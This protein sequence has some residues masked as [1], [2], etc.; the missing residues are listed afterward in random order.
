MMNAL[1]PRHFAV[2]SPPSIGCEE[3][4]AVLRGTLFCICFALLTPAWAAAPVDLDQFRGRVV[5]LDFWASWCG[6]CKQSFPWMQ[7]MTNAYTGHGLSV[8]AVNLDTDRADAEKFLHEFRPTFEVR[9]D[10]KGAYAEFYHVKGMPSSV[11]IDRHGVSRFTHVGFL[12]VDGSVLEAQ[13][14]ELLA[15]K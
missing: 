1:T 14:Q 15:E 12:P 13:V 5:Y 2:Q 11:L 9:F 6:P 10:P 4:G 3:T 8:V 7:A